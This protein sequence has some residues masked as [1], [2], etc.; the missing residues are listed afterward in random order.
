[1]RKEA[2]EDRTAA[3]EQAEAIGRRCR[4]VCSLGQIAGVQE[5]LGRKQPVAGLIS[6]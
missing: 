4:L 2:C 5:R 1:M 3:S 6:S